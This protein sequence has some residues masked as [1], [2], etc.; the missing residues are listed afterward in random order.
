MDCNTALND[1]V[2][3]PTSPKVYEY[4]SSV[5][6]Y[7]YTT[8]WTDV[9]TSTGETKGCPVT[10]CELRDATCTDTIP[11]VNTNF[12]ITSTG[13]PWALTAKANEEAGWISPNMVATSFCFRCMGTA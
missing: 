10:S 13:S 2:S 3:P 1:V 7:A 6:T 12:W 11:A 4:S 9:F 5:S 8:T